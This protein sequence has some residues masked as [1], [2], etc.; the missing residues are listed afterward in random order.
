MVKVWKIFDYP[1]GQRLEPL[2]K[3]EIDRLRKL[4]EI[5]CSDEVAGKLN[6]ISSASVD[7]KLEHE[8]LVLW[9]KRK[10]HLGV[11]PP[12]EDLVNISSFLFQQQPHHLFIFSN[13][14]K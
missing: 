6:N 3:D 12:S 1:C 9:Q 4:K 5:N 11:S 13:V 8:K 7:R 10:Y 2:L 14:F